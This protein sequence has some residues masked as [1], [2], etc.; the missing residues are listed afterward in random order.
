MQISNT[1]E[2]GEEI[3][4]DEQVEGDDLLQEPTPQKPAMSVTEQIPPRYNRESELEADVK[5]G[6]NTFDFSLTSQQ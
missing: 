6:E 4:E 2:F 3:V 1:E 5:P